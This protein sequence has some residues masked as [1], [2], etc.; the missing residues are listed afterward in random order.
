MPVARRAQG[1]RA[2][3]TGDGNALIGR[4]L[5]FRAG[6][7]SIRTKLMLIS[8]AATVAGLI[9]I[10]SLFLVQDLVITRRELLESV[11]VCAELIGKN[12]TTALTAGNAADARGILEALWAEPTVDAAWIYTPDGKLQASYFRDHRE[13]TP[14]P[15]HVGQVYSAFRD[16]HLEVY[17]P[18][19]SNGKLIG[20]VVIRANLDEIGERYRIY[21]IMAPLALL[22][23]G[24]CSLLL[25]GRLMS[26][27]TRPIL[28]MTSTAQAVSRDKH[29]ELRVTRTSDDELG[30]LVQCFNTMLDEIQHRDAQLKAHRDHLEIQ[31]AQRTAELTRLNGEITVARDRAEAASRAKSS[32]LANM[33]HEIRTPMTAIVGYADIMLEPDQT[34]SDRQDCLQAVRRNAHHLLELIN[35]ILDLSKIE[36][37]KMTVERLEVN[38]PQLVADVSSMIRPR[39]AEKGLAFELEFVTPLP[40]TIQTDPLR[41]KQILMNLLGN[42]VKF[43]PRGKVGMKVRVDCSGAEARA[44]FEVRDSGIG[45]SSDQ[46]AR[47]FQSFSQADESTTRR[48]GGTGLGLAISQ[49]LARLLGGS[50]AVCSE[51]DRG[52]VFRLDIGAG[53]SEGAPM[54]HDVSEMTQSIREAAEAPAPLR[55]GGRILV[56]EDGLD[57]QRLIA[58]HLRRAG[59]E[60]TIAP[61]GKVAVELMQRETFDLVIMDMQMPVLDGYGAT[62][63]LRSLGF[64]QP[65]IA[66]TAHAMPEDRARCIAA[67]CSE[68]LTKP[69]DKDQ[70]LQVVSRL[71]AGASAAPRPQP[72]ASAAAQPAVLGQTHVSEFSADP[73]MQALVEG[74]VQRLPVE[75]SKL[76][77]LLGQQDMEGLHRIAHQ[78][79]GSGGGYGFGPITE[80]AAAADAAIK[81]GADVERIRAQIDAL[82]GYIREIRGYNVA[83]EDGHGSRDPGH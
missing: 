12:S 56:A 17:R 35:D 9:V 69:I 73:D 23:A 48:F 22:A 47:M 18:I 53:P 74:Y 62:S 70:F 61:N 34:L 67:G 7:F 63:R 39:A 30:E 3:Q 40:R 26:L 10:S 79:K 76:K 46:L 51:P 13:P 57:N 32:F 38:L 65:I 24:A 43:T 45:M 44:I 77:S 20:A 54:L 6:N 27:I 72:K 21:G 41:L 59:A 2:N 80:L 82:V 81:A 19:T 37:N 29:F 66:L 42:A 75:V 58:A 33:S 25:G 36:A 11:G 1:W 4:P 28:Q 15:E 64:T 55:I 16:E 14:S 49:R 83:M 68:Y 31:V 60:V 8:M 78:L 50:I 52:S 5:R 71:L